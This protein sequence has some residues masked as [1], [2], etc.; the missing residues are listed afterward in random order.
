MMNNRVPFNLIAKKKDFS[1]YGDANFVQNRKSNSLAY[2]EGYLLHV[3][4]SKSE[5]KELIKDKEYGCL[6]QNIKG[7][8]AQLK[9]NF[10]LVTIGD[11]WFNIDGD[12]F[13]IQ[14]WFYWQDGDQFVV[15]DS[16]KS[17]V[18]LI[19][20]KLS[21]H[22]MALYAITYHFINGKTL[23]DG[24]YHNEPSQSV[25]YRK[26][27]MK[28]SIYWSP[29]ELLS[30]PNR[31]VSIKQIVEC[32]GSHI[33]DLLRIA[34]DNPIS[35]S[36]TG[37]ADTRNLLALLL[38]RGF[39]PHLYTY[40]NPNSCDCRKA[41][42]VAK[43]L[44]LQH[45]IYD[46]R[47][48]VELF[49]QYTKEIIRSGNSL[50]SLHRVHR[51]MAVEKERKYASTM[52]LGTLGGEFVKGVSED[53]YIVPDIIYDNWQKQKLD[54]CDIKRYLEKKL[55][56]TNALNLSA[57][58]LELCQRYIDGS[59]EERKMLSLTHITAHLHDAQDIIM[60]QQVMERVFT[61]FLDIDYLELLFS[62]SYSY[63]NKEKIRNRIIRRVQNPV[64]ASYFIRQVYPPLGKYRYSGEH[65]PNEV[66][67]NPYFAALM[68]GIRQRI[69]KH[70]PPNFPL[71]EW[72]QDFI[73]QEL[74]KCKNFNLI[75]EIYDIDA[76]TSEFQIRPYMPRESHL[77][78]FTN[79]IMF[80]YIAEELG[81]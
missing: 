42:A 46:I 58:G 41:S 50:T 27:E 45:S 63:N 60:Y 24:I 57:L 54:E 20:P 33:N 14:K 26:G 22:N 52:F 37:G 38:E 49:R 2:V 71:G 76:L 75:S 30:Q 56:N 44:Q 9:G 19:K 59:Q 11:D 32:L 31:G 29:L 48:T 51:I 13:G 53:N 40:G 7:Y 66:I 15:S 79:P 3:D 18:S 39:K 77:L 1:L 4:N 36:L 78:K 21:T 16:L 72:M 5:V 6:T 23:F 62:S 34:P 67:L 74:P 73:Q 80:R 35:L 64:Y 68:K 28:I 12:R 47:M 17:M 8:R 55:I 81:C 43:G 61:P 69:K 25:E 10:T 65:I 70:H